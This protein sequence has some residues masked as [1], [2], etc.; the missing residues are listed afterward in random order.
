MYLTEMLLKIMMA[1]SIV[2]VILVFQADIRRMIDLIGSLSN[3]HKKKKKPQ[4]STIDVLI[5]ACS[6]MAREKTGALIVLTG[7]EPLER[8]VHGGIELSG[9][10]SPPLLYSIFSTKSP[11]HDGAMLMDGSEITRFAV[12]LNLSKNLSEI[13]QGG[14]RHAAAL[15]LSED[16]D[17][18]AIVVS[19][20]RGTI[21]V[22][23]NGKLSIMTSPSELKSRIDAFWQKKYLHV[24]D[25]SKKTAAKKV[26][27]ISV[28][29]LLSVIIWFFFAYQ[30]DVVYRTFK[31]PVEFRNMNKEYSLADFSPMQVQ[32]TLHGNSQAF[33]LMDPGYLAASIDVSELSRGTNEV[34]IDV[35]NI[36]VTDDI[37]VYDVFPKKIKVRLLKKE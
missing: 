7:R 5:E 25:R 18:L 13:G 21:S 15:G 11:G 3:V 6:R 34:N 31:V 26:K 27:A 20:E 24:K 36:K 19:E 29:V 12:H 8:Q 17:S 9:K 10:V 28:S 1:V 33:R 37:K 16:S 23:E 22:A 14:T 2:A 32:V 30:S 35:K 4:N